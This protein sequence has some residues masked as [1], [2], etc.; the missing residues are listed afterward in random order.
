MSI[1][2]ALQEATIRITG[3]IQIFENFGDSPRIFRESLKYAT[4]QGFPEDFVGESRL[5]LF[6]TVRLTAK[7]I[8]DELT[9]H[10]PL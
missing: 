8:T 3:K 2:R 9:S 10:C 4:P 7:F 5:G 6:G 1:I